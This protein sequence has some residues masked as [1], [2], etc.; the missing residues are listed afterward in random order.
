[1]PQSGWWR[2]MLAALCA[3]RPVSRHSMHFDC[4]L[5]LLPTPSFRASH[6]PDTCQ[7]FVWRWAAG[8][9]I[10]RLPLRRRKAQTFLFFWFWLVILLRCRQ[11]SMVLCQLHDRF[12]WPL[13]SVLHLQQSCDAGSSLPKLSFQWWPAHVQTPSRIQHLKHLQQM[14]MRDLVPG[15][16]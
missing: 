6:G 10:H 3:Q 13:G 1:M 2:T 14:G 5:G 12:A 4:S 8:A 9:N 7:C 11:K 15:S 16:W